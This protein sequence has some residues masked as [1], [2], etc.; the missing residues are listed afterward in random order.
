LSL[1][2]FYYNEI[3]IF[4][5]EFLPGL[6]RRFQRRAGLCGVSASSGHA[7]RWP[8]LPPLQ[9]LSQKKD[10]LNKIMPYPEKCVKINLRYRNL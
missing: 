3:F 4:M 5:I 6:S 2:F 10:F 8:A 7:L 9:S 1:S